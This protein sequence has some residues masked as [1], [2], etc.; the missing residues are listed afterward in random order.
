MVDK[1]PFTTVLTIDY[2]TV[3][4]IQLIS[5]THSKNS[6]ILIVNTYV[7]T[8]GIANSLSENQKLLESDTAEPVL[9]SE[10]L[11]IPASGSSLQ[12]IDQKQTQPCE[13]NRGTKTLFR[14]TI[15]CSHAK[16]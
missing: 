13:A 14:R 5:I 2:T 15:H 8:F 3:G 11:S 6:R 9:K 4:D 7:K 12:T 1:L 10:I 16:Y